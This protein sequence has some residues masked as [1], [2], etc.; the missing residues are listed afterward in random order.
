MTVLDSIDRLFPLVEG[1]I[2]L[3]TV[4]DDGVVKMETVDTRGDWQGETPTHAGLKIHT[5][6]RWRYPEGSNTVFWWEQPTKEEQWAVEGVL[7]KRGYRVLHHKEMVDGSIED[8]ISHGRRRL[9]KKYLTSES[10]D[11]FYAGWYGS[12]GGVFGQAFPTLEQAEHKNLN[13]GGTVLKDEPWR[14]RGDTGELFLWLED[15]GETVR[16]V[17]TMWDSVNDKD[18]PFH[19]SHGYY[20]DKGTKEKIYDPYKS[21]GGREILGDSLVTRVIDQLFEG[22]GCPLCGRPRVEGCRCSSRVVHDI[23]SLKDGH[24]CKCENGHRWTTQTADGQIIT[25]DGR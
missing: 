23:Q 17:H 21:P 16:S 7:A 10:A 22:T 18:G 25:W 8:E 5:G 3:G 12:D 9:P 11:K 2:V 4:D 20:I 14:F 13:A 24:G 15:R 6:T 19:R 1:W